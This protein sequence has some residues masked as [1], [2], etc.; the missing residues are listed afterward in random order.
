MMKFLLQIKVHLDEKWSRNKK[1][2]ENV[3]IFNKDNIIR[4]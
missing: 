2:S 4:K 3:Y 1:S